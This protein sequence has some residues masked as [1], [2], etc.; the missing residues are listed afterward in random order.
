MFFDREFFLQALPETHFLSEHFPIEPE[1]YTDSR[2]VVPGSIFCAL[3]GA[4][5]DGHDYIE[6]ALQRGAAG[7]IAEHQ[8]RSLFDHLDI[9]L[10][11]NTL[12]ALVPDTI[13]ALCELARAWRAKFRGTIVGITGSLGKTSTKELLGNIIDRAGIESCVSYGNQNTIIG[14]PLNVLKLREHH[15]VGVFEL[16]ISKPGEL[17]R[18]VDVL[19][20]DTAMITNIAH[21]HVE[22]FG[23]L[24]NIAVE[25]QD[26]F[27]YFGERSIGIINGDVPFLAQT[28]YQH[29]VIR[30]GLKT[31]N[32]IQM[33]R[34][35]RVGDTI[36]GVLNLYKR[37]Y[38]VVLRHYNESIVNTVLAA[39]AMACHLGIPDEAIVEVVQE[40][41]R[42]YRRFERKRIKGFNNAMLIDDGYNA[43]PESMKAALSGFQEIVG[44]GKK[45]AIIGDM[46]ELGHMSSFWHRQLGRCL[47]KTST[48]AH[49]IL[50]GDMVQWTHQMLESDDGVTRVANWQEAADVVQDILEDDVL[51]LVKGSRSMKLEGVVERI[52]E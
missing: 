26:V 24:P 44:Q 32:Q 16:G 12:I 37:H 27:H 22:A 15:K 48:L 41:F 42:M 23:T 3:R 52:C 21:M 17:R 46:A 47:S 19:R 33:R 9:G 51:I 43:G 11:A 25:K 6:E 7:I 50:V 8:S 29:P 13:K 5:V 4:H 28:S 35:K 2:A 38:P 20:P 36:T 18:L 34:V 39:S 49:I 14:M 1:F 10:L 31:T 40:P 30:F 45:I